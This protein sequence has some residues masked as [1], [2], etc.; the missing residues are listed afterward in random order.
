[1]KITGIEKL[2]KLAAKVRS[3]P[4]VGERAMYRALNQTGAKVRTLAIREVTSELNLKTAYVRDK[5]WMLKAGPGRLQVDI[6]AE[7][8]DIRLTNYDARQ[9]TAPAVRAKGDSLRGIPGGRKQAGVSVRVG[10]GAPRKTIKSAFL[11]P[12]RAGKTSGG[13]GLG[14]F[15]RGSDLGSVGKIGSVTPTTRGGSRFN[16]KKGELKQLYGPAVYQVF[17]RFKKHVLGEQG[18]LFGPSVNVQQ[19]LAD[20]FREQ[21]RYELTGS[22]KV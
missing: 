21:L 15:V 5:I 3:V 18:D 9:V 11:L 17:L 7:R 10:K 14:V 19:M 16:W 8:D 20:A 13:N 4:A 12:L 6:I 1:M 2:A 22:R